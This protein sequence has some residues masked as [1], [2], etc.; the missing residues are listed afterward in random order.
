MHHMHACTHSC[1]R[2]LTYRWGLTALPSLP[3]RVLHTYRRS[4]GADA[5]CGGSAG[6][7][8]D[9]N[10]DSGVW[11]R[12]IATE[13]GTL[14]GSPGPGLAPRSGCQAAEVL[15]SCANRRAS[16]PAAQS[17]ALR[18]RS[19]AESTVTD[20][21]KQR[22]EPEHTSTQTRKPPHRHIDS[23][24]ATGAAGSARGSS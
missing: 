21:N 1:R 9:I 17:G 18:R 19:A 3:L 5:N 23:M 8:R 7:K 20:R 24:N 2:R 14:H 15:A 22:R 6:G 10:R 13:T 11:G 16:A 12:R 4:Q